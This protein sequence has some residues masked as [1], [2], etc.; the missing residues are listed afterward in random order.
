M[1]R[2]RAVAGLARPRLADAHIPQAPRR[3]R[4]AVEPSRRRP[5]LTPEDALLPLE[6]LGMP[7]RLDNPDNLE[8]SAQPEPAGDTDFPGHRAAG[9]GDGPSPAGAGSPT[10]SS[11]WT[12]GT[13]Q[14][15]KAARLRAAADIRAASGINATATVAITSQKA[16]TP[17]DLPTQTKLHIGTTFTLDGDAYT[18][19]AWHGQSVVVSSRTGTLRHLR[20]IDL[21]RDPTLRLRAAPAPSMPA[22]GHHFSNLTSEQIAAVAERVA[23]VNEVLTGYRSGHSDLAAPDEPRPPYAPDVDKMSRYRAKADELGISLMTVRRWCGKFLTDGPAGL[24]D[25]RTLQQSNILSRVD[26]RWIDAAKEVLARHTTKSRPSQNKVIDDIDDLLEERFPATGPDGEAVETVPRPSM[27]T[28]REVLRELARGTN[29]FKGSAK[30]KRSIAN[31]PPSVYGRLRAQRAGQYI[32]ADTTV[33][34]VYAMEPVSLRW[35]RVQLTVF[36][37][38]FTRCITAIRLTPYS[39]KAVDIGLCLYKTISLD[40]DDRGALPYLGVPGTAVLN[41]H[42]LARAEGTPLLPSLHVDTLVTDLGSIY[43]SEHIRAVCARLGISLQPARPYTPTDKPPVER[44]FRTLRESL[45]ERL[46][47]Y[48]GPDVD[49]R[50][51]N[52]ENDAYFFL[53]ELEELI[54]DWICRVYHLTPHDGLAIPSVPGIDVSPLQMLEHDQTVNGQLPVLTD[55]NLAFDFLPVHWKTIQHYGIEHRTLRYGGPASDDPNRAATEELLTRLRNRT[56]PYIG[57]HAGKWPIRVNDDDISRI[58]LQDPDDDTWHAV[59][60]EHAV[61]LGMPFSAEALAHARKITVAQG[62]NFS[63][64][65]ALRELVSKWLNGMAEG[66]AERRMAMR[67]YSNETSVLTGKYEAALFGDPVD[68]GDLDGETSAEQALAEARRQYLESDPDDHDPTPAEDDVPTTSSSTRRHRVRAR[69]H[70]MPQLAFDLHEDSFGLH[71]DTG[72]DTELTTNHDK[73]NP[74][75]FRLG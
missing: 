45:L 28:A 14:I 40:P 75:G 58:Y 3:N 35:V 51:L 70:G 68:P 71:R 25:E 43:V 53:D 6:E 38:L 10:P 37:D 26:M 18:L 9:D 52:V 21:L 72:T 34:D 63:P 66:P 73:E 31:R 5:R 55:P 69:R 67:L 16:P 65:R 61:A 2:Q 44:F 12:P 20:I 39:T 11:G 8:G 27:T 17:A 60:W 30:S 19:T 33:L 24:L 36:M 74:H 64:R 46:P 23:H 50:G 29:A 32:L 1:T 54:I 4:R 47:S 49:S 56:S 62:R 13:F 57:V 48:K 42:Q 22:W 41:V 59:A 15:N 7:V